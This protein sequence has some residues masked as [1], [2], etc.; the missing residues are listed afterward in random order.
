MSEPKI[1]SVAS[2]IV[3]NKVRITTVLEFSVTTLVQAKLTKQ[4]SLIL[5]MIAHGLGNRQI[6][7]KLAITER[8]VKFHVTNLLK[9][10]GVTSR[11]EL[12]ATRR[13]G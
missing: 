10:S 5:P 3:E 9:K 7:D 2:E 8:G 4:E 11:T 12:M 6:A 1:I 13:A